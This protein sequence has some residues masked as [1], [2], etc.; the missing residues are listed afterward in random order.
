[1]K[2]AFACLY[3]E[4]WNG[5]LKP[6]EPVSERRPNA[7]G[8]PARTSAVSILSA[9]L[10]LGLAAIHV[11]AVRLRLLDRIPRSRWLSVGGGVSVAYV[12]VH[13]LPELGEHQ[14]T[15][16]GAG[17]V[18]SFADRHVYLLALVGFASFYGLER[19]AQCSR[20]NS[21]TQRSTDGPVVEPA[22]TGGVFWLHVGSFAIYNVLIGYLLV[23]RE[24]PGVA[25][26][27]L[28]T[29]AM[30]LHFL[31][32][33]TGLRHHH[34]GAYD[35]VGRWLLALAVVAGWLLGMAVTVGTLTVGMLTAFLGGGIVLNVIKEELP[36]ERESRFW[37]FAAGAA[38]Y[39]VLL[40]A[41]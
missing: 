40:L 39:T 32:N 17:P 19:L 4:K 34:R 13:L 18:A 21:N 24:A 30:G 16:A 7:D 11:L 25:S 33:D 41:F 37:A 26:L 12:F 28:F 35:H 3:W 36:A 14:E 8:S 10:A 38:G 5:R 22:A 23:H 31:V 2:Q 9:T 1:M 15:F 29:V 6:V 20:S 27:L